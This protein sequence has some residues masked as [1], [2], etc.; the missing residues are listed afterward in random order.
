MESSMAE[1][2]PPATFRSPVRAALS[3]RP[4]QAFPRTLF[5]GVVHDAFFADAQK[6]AR[7][8]SIVTTSKIKQWVLTA[9]ALLCLPVLL[10]PVMSA[11]TTF[12]I[13]AEDGAAL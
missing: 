13:P 8:K 12:R 7:R 6:Q 10:N 11:T 2:A 5:C 1:S 3:G 4:G 9:L